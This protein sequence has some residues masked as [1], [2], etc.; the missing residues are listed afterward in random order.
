[1]CLLLSLSSSLHSA[2]RDV[3]KAQLG[4]IQCKQ[5]KSENY[6]KI[7]N[8]IIAVNCNFAVVDE[9]SLLVANGRQKLTNHSVAVKV[10]RDASLMQKEGLISDPCVFCYFAEL[11]LAVMWLAVGKAVNVGEEEEEITT[12]TGWLRRMLLTGLCDM[13]KTA[14]VILSVQLLSSWR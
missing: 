6:R 1:M 12:I 8:Q 4:P 11:L 7:S 13:L 9:L 10:K 5:L 14:L 3:L 2:E